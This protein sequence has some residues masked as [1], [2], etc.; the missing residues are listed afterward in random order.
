MGRAPRE[1]DRRHG[2][3][4]HAHGWLYVRSI[5]VA[6]VARG[7]GLGRALL[8]AV[9][10]FAAEHR[11]RRLYLSTTP[12]LADAIR[13]YEAAG[14]TWDGTTSEHRFDCGNRPIVRY[15]KELATDADRSRSR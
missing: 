6:P 5:A 1:R 11:A 12:F 3:R 4:G 14:W 10:A 2:L 9:E 13:F 8:V 15:A 7:H